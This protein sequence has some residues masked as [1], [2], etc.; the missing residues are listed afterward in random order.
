MKNMKRNLTFVSLLAVLVMAMGFT[1]ALGSVDTVEFNG[2][3]LTSGNVFVAVSPGE[4]VPVWVQF[5]ADEDASD[6]T[7]EVEIKGRNGASAFKELSDVEIGSTYASLLKLKLPETDD[8]SE[9]FTL[10]VTIA[11][12]T[13]EVRETF[14]VSLRVQR[15]SFDLEVL[16]VDYNS[17]VE[18][19]DVFPVSVVVKNTGYNR[20][21]DVYVIAS[22][23]AL[24]ISTRGYAGDLIPTEDCDDDCDDE[25]DS[26]EEMV[27]LQVPAD[28]ESGVYEMTIE[29]YNR[30]SSTEVS[31][32]ISVNGV[33][34]ADEDAEDIDDDS[35]STSVV[36][37]TVILVIIFVVLL[38]VLVVL[39]TRREKPIE[40]VETSYY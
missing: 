32:L 12:N 22:I 9:E 31:K 38:A 7:L 3:S 13:D 1:S 28:A 4:V 16:S 37:L 26:V 30:D 39:L 6:V 27:Y 35:V 10:Y 18:S 15:E 23:P 34:P 2:V 5:T 25:E 24:G 20:A 8:L 14:D 33:N 36:A 40:E 21:D 19:G 17:K 11:S 29:V